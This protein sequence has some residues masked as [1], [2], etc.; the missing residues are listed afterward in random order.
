[1]ALTKLGDGV[2]IM[3]PRWVRA[4]ATVWVAIDSKKRGR[5]NM[6]WTIVVLIL[7]PLLL[8]FYIASRPMMKNEKGVDCFF[9]RLWKAF[10]DLFVWITALASSAVFIENMTTPKSREL[11]EV[12]RAEIKAGSILSFIFLVIAIG[13][14]KFGF[15]SVNELIE[16]KIFK[17]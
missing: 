10:E 11:S 15:D 12:K 9:W 4:L 5:F 8:P 7:G 6:T 3:W 14:E 16:E 17:K 2:V 1:M 13:L